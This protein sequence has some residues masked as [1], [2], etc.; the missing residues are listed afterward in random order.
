[1]AIPW[2]SS[3]KVKDLLF[4]MISRGSFQEVI[5]NPRLRYKEENGDKSEDIPSSVWRGN[6]RYARDVI[7]AKRTPPLEKA[8]DDNG[9]SITSTY[10]RSLGSE[11]GVE[12]RERQRDH[13]IEEPRRGRGERHSE[14]T[15]VEREC[16]GAV[17]EGD[18]PFSRRICNVEEIDPERDDAHTSLEVFNPEGKA[19]HEQKER[20][21]RESPKE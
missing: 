14:I 9:A 1:M 4:V 13:E 8:L 5:N 18:R 6:V 11:C 12:A 10:E 3:S 7:T 19:G 2:S 16:F 15:D 17:G 21:E 20:H